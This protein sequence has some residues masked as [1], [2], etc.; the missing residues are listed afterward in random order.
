[1]RLEWELFWVPSPLVSALFRI[2]S[3][4]FIAD[5]S[6]RCSAVFAAF[7]RRSLRRP[8]GLLFADYARKTPLAMSA[9]FS[10]K[11]SFSGKIFFGFIFQKDFGK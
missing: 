7:L 11:N 2:F 4:S 6:W 9:N 10:A 5:F 1:M 3:G 8:L